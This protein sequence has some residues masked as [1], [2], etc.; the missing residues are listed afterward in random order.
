MTY[1]FEEDIRNFNIFQLAGFI[2]NCRTAIQRELNLFPNDLAEWN[3]DIY[4]DAVLRLCEEWEHHSQLYADIYASKNYIKALLWLSM[5]RDTYFLK[6]ELTEFDISDIVYKSLMDYE[7]PDLPLSNLM[8]SIHKSEIKKLNNYESLLNFALKSEDYRNEIGKV[9]SI[10]RYKESI[11]IISILENIDVEEVNVKYWL[12]NS[13]K[14]KTESQ[15]K[16]ND[17]KQ[18]SIVKVLSDLLDGA[19][20][21][22]SY[23]DYINGDLKDFDKKFFAN[24]SFFLY[25]SPPLVNKLFENDGYNVKNSKRHQDKILKKCYKIGFTRDYANVLLKNAGFFNVVKKS[26]VGYYYLDLRPMGR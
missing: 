22:Q 20:T 7:E 15:I 8:S 9:I 21:K 5:K 24:L 23:Y 14:Y 1:I 26:K 13:S 10:E 4:E 6:T 17:S 16:G 3:K 19:I 18:H 11:H 12:R 25:L 2:N